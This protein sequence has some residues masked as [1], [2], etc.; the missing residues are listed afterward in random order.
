MKKN[1]EKWAAKIPE[2]Q[3]R[4]EGNV[5]RIQN[6]VIEEAKSESEEDSESNKMS[7]FTDS[8]PGDITISDYDIE[9]KSSEERKEALNNTNDLLNEGKQKSAEI[10]RR[11]SSILDF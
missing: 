2:Y 5:K 6:D 1:R 3:D 4:M 11:K 10:E 7:S 8:S 9:K